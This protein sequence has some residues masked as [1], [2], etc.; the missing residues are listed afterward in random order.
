[1]IPVPVEFEELTLQFQF[2]MLSYLG[3]VEA[4]IASALSRTGDQKKKVIQE[5]LFDLLSGKY[6]SDAI[7]A[8]WA[9]T[10]ADFFVRGDEGLRAFLKLIQQRCANS[11]LR[12]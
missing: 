4:M 11:E 12:G 8:V 2:E 10:S 7:E 5:F 1:M 3:S 6:D 9:G